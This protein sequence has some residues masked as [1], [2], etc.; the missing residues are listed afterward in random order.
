[1]GVTTYLYLVRRLLTRGFTPSIP[2][3]PELYGAKLSIEITVFLLVH[4]FPDDSVCM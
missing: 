3:M 2:R 1:M 4:N